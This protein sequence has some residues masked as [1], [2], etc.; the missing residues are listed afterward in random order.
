MK[1]KYFDE[2]GRYELGKGVPPPVV[3]A[4]PLLPGLSG[5]GYWLGGGPA[6]SSSPPPQHNI[7]HP[8]KS[9]NYYNITQYPHTIPEE[10]EEE[11]KHLAIKIWKN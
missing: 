9:T 4:Q 5:V 6:A 1:E 8:F 10:E 2:M 3:P 11:E 7:S